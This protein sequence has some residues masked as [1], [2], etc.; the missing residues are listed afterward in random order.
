MVRTNLCRQCWQKPISPCPSPPPA[1]SSIPSTN[2][3]KSPAP[4]AHNLH[5]VQNWPH[6]VSDD[7]KIKC[8]WDYVTNSTWRRRGVCAVCG[9]N[10]YSVC[11]TTY[12]L[13][14]NDELPRAVKYLLCIKPG[15][16]FHND[17][18][19]QFG[20]HAINNLMLFARA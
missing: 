19:F 4:S 7:L 5:D 16:V 15:S 13:D 8:M 18:I 20:H 10:H 9:R 11:M 3:T 6:I 2:Y 17:V 1:A 12:E 14:R